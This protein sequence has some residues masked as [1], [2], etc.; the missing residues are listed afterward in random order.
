MIVLQIA[1]TTLSRAPSDIC[2]NHDTMLSEVAIAMKLFALLCRA[3]Y[4][5]LNSKLVLDDGEL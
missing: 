4:C 5:S 2:V 3:N 1:G